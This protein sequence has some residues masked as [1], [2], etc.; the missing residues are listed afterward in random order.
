MFLKSLKIENNS[1]LIRQID[2]RKGLNLIVD[3]TPFRDEKTGNNVGKTTVLRLIDYCLGGNA[4]DIF[5]D[6]ENKNVNTKVKNFLESTKVIISLT[7]TRELDR[8]TNDVVIRRNFLLRKEA[9]CQINGKNV[10]KDDFEQELSQALWNRT[11][12][13]PSFRQVISHNIRID[14]SRIENALRTLNRYSKNIEYESLHLFM[15]GCDFE[16]GERRQEIS[17]KL[18]TEYNFKRR[19]EKEANKSMLSSKLALLEDEIEKLNEQKDSLNLNPNFESDL[20]AFNE[21]Q[22]QLTQ[23]GTEL[24]QKQLRKK[25]ILEAIDDLKQ[26]KSKIDENQLASIYAQAKKLVPAIQKTFNDLLNYHN[27][28]ADNKAQFIGLELPKIDEEIKR[29]EENIKKTNLEKDRLSK[30]VRKSGSY[31]TINELIVQLNDKFKE[32]GALEQSIKQ[33]EDS[34]ATIAENLQMLNEIDEGLYSADKKVLIQKQLDKFNRFFSTISN[35]LYREQYAVG[36]DIREDRNGTPFYKFDPFS[37]NFSTGKKQGEVT[38]FELAYIQFAESEGIPCLHF[39]LN[40][41]KE[42][43][44]DNQLEK[45]GRLVNEREDIQYVASILK[46]K[47]PSEL[48]NAENIVLQLS[49]EDKLFRF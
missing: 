19:I 30:L 49:Q 25:L 39:V 3:E 36:F 46:D 45:I 26:N 28:M 37:T 24:S 42:L 5:T 2:F 40:D 16:N 23:Y 12:S 6:K 22:F 29:I 31:E 14:D 41:K 9:I 34:E 7:C 20:T 44:H 33:I 47:L 48:N 1:G 38:C 17:K 35:E 4:A 11:F 8:G 32:K 18:E 10:G 27:Q 43:V 13:K 15:F 21:V